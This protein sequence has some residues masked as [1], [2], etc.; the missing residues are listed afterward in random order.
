MAGYPYA[1][2]ET[3]TKQ[4][5]TTNTLTLCHTYQ[6][7]IKLL[8]SVNIVIHNGSALYMFNRNRYQIY[9]NCITLLSLFYSCPRSQYL[10]I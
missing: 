5:Q 8:N 10:Y 1:L 7:R 3:H 2:T 9:E 4:W 6:I